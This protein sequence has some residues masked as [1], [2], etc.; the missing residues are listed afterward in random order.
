MGYR[1]FVDGDGV[2]WRV[3]ETRPRTGANVRPALAAG[4]VSFE[5]GETRR[6]LTPVPEGWDGGSDEDLRD[7][8]GQATEVAEVETDADG[9]TEPG[10]AG[11][12]G[13][14]IRRAREVLRT[15]QETLKRTGYD[16]QPPPDR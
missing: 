6:R 9:S 5:S 11:R 15:V 16:P 7:L 3:W 12:T 8:L 14:V 1:E 2:E 4:W 13:S 10:L